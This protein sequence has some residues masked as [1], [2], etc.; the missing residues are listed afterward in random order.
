MFLERMAYPETRSYIRR[1]FFNLLQ[2]YRIYRPGMLA[3]YFP[4][5]RTGVGT[6]PGVSASPPAAET[7]VGQEA[8]PSHPGTDAPEGG[9]PRGETPRRFSGN[10]FRPPRRGRS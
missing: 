10:P 5:D 2:Y 3:R 6:A 9:K 8:P 4:S 1:V 7:P